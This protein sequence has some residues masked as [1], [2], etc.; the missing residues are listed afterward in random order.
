M[1]KRSPDRRS[2]PEDKAARQPLQPKYE[3]DGK[4]E[5]N[6]GAPKKKGK[7]DKSKDLEELKQEV[8]MVNYYLSPLNTFAQ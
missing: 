2:T 8:K 7:K 3:Q 5:S 6:Q 1:E 4:A